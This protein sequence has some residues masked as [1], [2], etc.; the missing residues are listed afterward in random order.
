MKQL[1]QK[2]Q[3][4]HT[5]A[6]FGTFDSKQQLVIYISFR[7]VVYHCHFCHSFLQYLYQYLI[8]KEDGYKKKGD[9]TASMKAEY[10][11]MESETIRYEAV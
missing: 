11:A 5:M 10:A 4:A 7:I 6:S 2:Q 3:V 9:I 1:Q 8:R